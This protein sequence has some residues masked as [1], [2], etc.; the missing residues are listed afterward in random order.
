MEAKA[1]RSMLKE[2][3]AQGK[4]LYMHAT[5]SFEVTRV[6]G[7]K[8]QGVWTLVKRVDGEWIETTGVFDI[9]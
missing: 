7:A 8:R 6:T 2:A 9:R 5:S 3:T 4:N 1:I